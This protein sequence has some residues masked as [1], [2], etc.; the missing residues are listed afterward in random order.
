MGKLLKADRNIAKTVI[1]LYKEIIKTLGEEIAMHDER[2]KLLDD[3]YNL[4]ELKAICKRKRR[5]IAWP[6][7]QEKSERSRKS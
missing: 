2:I 7:T 4:G 5:R 6:R 1:K 3:I